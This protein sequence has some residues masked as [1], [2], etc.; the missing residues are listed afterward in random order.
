MCPDGLEQPTFSADERRGLA[1]PVIPAT[2]KGCPACG[3]PSVAARPA[4]RVSTGTGQLI[5]AVPESL[6]G[7]VGG[8]DQTAVVTT[9]HIGAAGELLVQYLLLKHDIDSA[10]LTTDS[11][12]DLVVYSP[13]TAAATTVQVKTILAS[14]PAGGRGPL[15]NDWWFPHACPAD[16]L[17]LARLST[18]SVWIFTLDEAR[19]LAQQHND[20]GNRH[21]Y[22]YTD[23]MKAPQGARREGDV[24]RYTL[25]RRIA[26][27]F[28]G[29]PPGADGPRV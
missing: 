23:E 24:A 5:T 9:Q 1:G 17:A 8:I 6:V 7:L 26:E 11:G 4:T 19:D 28:L 2:V 20:K 18:D 29:A 3:R 13:L 21:L 12:V 16:M 25:D 10:R 22:W 15:A 14:K 27:L